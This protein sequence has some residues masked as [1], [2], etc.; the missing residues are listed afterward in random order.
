[1]RLS[2]GQPGK[3]LDGLPQ[4]LKTFC[5][6]NINFGILVLVDGFLCSFYCRVRNLTWKV[7]ISTTSVYVEWSRGKILAEAY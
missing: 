1:M 3:Y 7:L 6:K 5:V 2:N 4:G